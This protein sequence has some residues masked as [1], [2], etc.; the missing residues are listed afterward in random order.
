MLRRLLSALALLLVGLGCSHSNV[1]VLPSDLVGYWTTNDVHYRGRFLELN[2]A[3]VIIGAGEKGSPGVQMIDR[4]ESQPLPDG[5][6]Y[7]IYS[8]TQEGMHDQLTI[9]FRP[10]NGGEIRFQHEGAVWKRSEI[11]NPDPEPSAPPDPQ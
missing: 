11:G 3:F 5:T 9:E 1:K 6:S 7:T 8:T 2:R 10:A 4:I